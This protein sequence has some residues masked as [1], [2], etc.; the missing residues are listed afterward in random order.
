MGKVTARTARRRQ[1]HRR[2]RAGQF[3]EVEDTFSYVSKLDGGDT[4]TDFEKGIDKIEIK[5]QGFVSGGVRPTK[6]IIDD[7][8]RATAAGPIFLYDTDDGRLLFDANGKTAG[9]QTSL[10]TLA[11][12]PDLSQ[13]DFLLF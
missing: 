7:D 4:I 5:T 13:G 12:G 10:A 11:G 3:G 1:A 8:P 2:H 9:G 6:M